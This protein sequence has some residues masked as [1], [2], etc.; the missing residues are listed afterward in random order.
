[1]K[2]I[3]W[4]GFEDKRNALEFYSETR[5]EETFR[6]PKRQDTIKTGPQGNRG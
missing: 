4:V 1:M 3:R 6:C 5:T 2:K